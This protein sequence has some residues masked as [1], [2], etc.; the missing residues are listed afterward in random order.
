MGKI[1]TCRKCKKP[2]EIK[3]EDENIHWVLRSQNYYYHRECWDEFTNIRREKDSEEW[4]D[5]TYYL[6]THLIK[7]DYN[8]FQI[9]RQM[10]TLIAS[11]KTPKGIFYALYWHYIIKDYNK[12]EGKYGIGIVPYIY[13][14]SA[15]YWY[16]R[17]SKRAGLMA[18]IEETIA[19]QESEAVK[20]RPVKRKR[21]VK[22]IDSPF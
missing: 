17:E 18:Q 20:I 12:W 3:V 5:L 15:S 21:K 7:G 1:V 6:I 10:Q 9:E 4:I 8:Y 2:F 22:E 14:N 19:I 16:E 13:D 11:G